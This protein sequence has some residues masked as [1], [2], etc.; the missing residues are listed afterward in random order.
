MKVSVLMRCREEDLDTNESLYIEILDTVHPRGYNLRCG[1]MAARPRTEQ[2]LSTHV[3]SPVQYDSKEDRRSVSEAVEDDIRKICRNA[4]VKPWAGVV[5]KSVEE[6]NRIRGARQ[7]AGWAGPRKGTTNEDYE[8][9]NHLRKQREQELAYQDR[10]YK[11]EEEEDEA[12][13]K[14]ARQE[15]DKKRKRSDKEHRLKSLLGTVSDLKK[16]GFD[17]EAG[18]ILKEYMAARLEK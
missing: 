5:K 9:N 18:T 3:H 17:E 1:K 14:E 10:K 4:E 16:M 8:R 6:V 11:R 13:I 15:R 7:F 12:K 2:A